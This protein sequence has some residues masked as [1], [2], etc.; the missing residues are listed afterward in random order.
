MIAIPF[1]AMIAGPLG[2]MLLGLDGKWGL[3]GWQWLFLLEGLP[4]VIFGFVVLAAL[5]DRPAEAPW[6]SD[7]QRHWLTARLEREEKASRAPHG[8]SALRAL[9][10]P[11]VWAVA[12]PCLLI[13]TAGYAFGFWAPTVI[14]DALQTSDAVTGV[15]IGVMAAASAVLMIATGVS[16]DRSGERRAAGIPTLKSQTGR[17]ASASRLRSTNARASASQAWLWIALPTT[18]AS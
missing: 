1:S 2:G 10:M 7:A 17:R 14:R 13:N 4:S 8:V 11:I 15:I 18:S 6:L 5:P 16:S 3:A 9:G 12:A